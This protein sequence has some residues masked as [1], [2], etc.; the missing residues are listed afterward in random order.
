MAGGIFSFHRLIDGVSK[1]NQITKQVFQ[2][3][4]CR[5]S[6]TLCKKDPSTQQKSKEGLS[7][8]NVERFMQ[9]YLKF[10]E[11][12]QSINHKEGFTW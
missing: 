8:K 10:K 12:L 6:F 3:Q 11:I 4:K 1:F 5:G 9:L 7:I 2:R